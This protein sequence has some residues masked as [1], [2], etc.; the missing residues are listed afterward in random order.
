MHSH[1]PSEHAHHHDF[2]IGVGIGERRTRGV[3]VLTVAMMV[4]E[5]VVGSITGSMA[6][7][8]DG[9]HMAT[10]AGALALALFAYWYARTRAGS[11]VYTF[12]TGK[13]YGL[14]GYSSGLILAIISLWMMV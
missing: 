8:A 3:V 9:W 4:A 12:G 5:L 14:A 11:D 6:L 10:H 13:V 1:D 7:I 2:A